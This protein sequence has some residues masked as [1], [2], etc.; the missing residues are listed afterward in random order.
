MANMQ[1]QLYLDANA[2]L[3]YVLM[4]IEEQ[5]NIVREKII[6][7][8]C[9]APLEVITEV[10]FVLDGVYQVPRSQAVKVFRKLS[11][12][13]IISNVDVFLRALEIYDKNPKIDLVDCLL[14]GYQFARGVDV[15]TFDKK[16]KNRLG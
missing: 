3:R 7:E 9:V 12:E 8:Y 11:S 4:D 6:K 2:I 1:Q 13:I 5:Y 14:Y 15:L 10:A 16:L